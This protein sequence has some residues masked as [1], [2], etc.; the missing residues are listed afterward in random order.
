MSCVLDVSLTHCV[1]CHRRLNISSLELPLLLFVS[2]PKHVSGALIYSISTNKNQLHK[3]CTQAPFDVLQCNLFASNHLIFISR[4][5]GLAHTIQ[6]VSRHAKSN[7]CVCRPLHQCAR[8]TVCLS[9]VLLPH[10]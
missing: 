7:S 8:T 5:G 6:V 1:A 4:G 3:N 2:R 10:V 9:H